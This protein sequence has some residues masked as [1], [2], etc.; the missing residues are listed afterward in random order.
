MRATK[1]LRIQSFTRHANCRL[2]EQIRSNSRPKGLNV[3]AVNARVLTV[4]DLS[5]YL[6]VHRSTIYRLLR[7]GQLPAFKIGSDWRFEVEAIDQWRLGKTLGNVEESQ[8]AR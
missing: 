7:Q 6:R 1:S 8:P 5:E 2:N 4:A 3:M